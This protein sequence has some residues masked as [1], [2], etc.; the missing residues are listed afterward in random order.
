[1]PARSLLWVVVA[2]LLVFWLIGVVINVIGALIH[3]LL[4]VAVIIVVIAL[5]RRNQV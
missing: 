2:A 3:L 1:M 4:L 5:Y